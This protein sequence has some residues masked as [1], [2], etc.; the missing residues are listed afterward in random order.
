MEKIKAI[1]EALIFASETLLA[2]EK[3]RTVL[4]EVERTEI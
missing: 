1:I 3:I 4:P 2:P